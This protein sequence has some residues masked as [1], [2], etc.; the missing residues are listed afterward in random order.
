MD[1]PVETPAAE[2]PFLTEYARGARAA[3]LGAVLGV[4]LAVLG[5]RR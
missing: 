5:R 1:G 4:L 3:I 2:Q